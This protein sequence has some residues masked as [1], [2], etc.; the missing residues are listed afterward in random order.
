MLAQPSVQ[1]LFGVLFFRVNLLE[2]DFNHPPA[3]R[4]RNSFVEVMNTCNNDYIS[5]E[6]SQGMVLNT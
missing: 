2:R 6:V 4:R 5:T 3:P 1:E